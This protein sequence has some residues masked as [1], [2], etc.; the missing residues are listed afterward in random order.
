[1]QNQLVSAL[2]RRLSPLLPLSV[3]RRLWIISQQGLVRWPPVG[4]VTHEALWRLQPIS[5][6]FGLDRG[7][8]IDRYYIERFLAT[9]SSA[10][11]GRVLEIAD[12]AYTRQFGGAKVTRSDVLHVDNVP[13]ATIVA[14]LTR[15][16]HLPSDTF[17]CIILTQ[18]LLVIYDIHAALR[19]VHRLLKPNGVLLATVPGIAKIS[20]Y[21][22]E[23]WGDYWRFTAYSARRMAGEVFADANIQV[24][25]HGNV[26]AAIALLHGLAQQDL[27]QA[28]LDY[29]DPD[30][31]LV[32][33]I[34]AVKRA[35]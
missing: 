15:A 19:T 29:H 12:D 13:E 28:E 10:I 31:H 25:A 17:D 5:R 32:V 30:Y 16:D 14:D 35:D 4:R 1:M 33:T 24:Q 11:K 2:I 20:R 7:K 3:R 9:H 8:P 27:T 18:T 34:R 22:A 6:V 21:D 26:L 23:R